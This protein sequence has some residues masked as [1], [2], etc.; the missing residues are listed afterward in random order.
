MRKAK[1]S[2]TARAKRA[3]PAGVCGILKRG[4]IAGKQDVKD[5]KRKIT[6]QERL[7]AQLTK[8]G[9][10]PAIIQKAKDVLASLQDKLS[11]DEAQLS[12]FR[13]EYAAAGCPRPIP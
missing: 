7:I 6:A 3:A 2:A 10:N 9:A 8:Q 13:D 5:D 1:R 4:I 11:T 12:A